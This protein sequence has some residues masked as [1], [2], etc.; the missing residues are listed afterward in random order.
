MIL[1]D[2]FNLIEKIKQKYYRQ[3][4]L[5]KGIGDDAAVFKQTNQSVVTAVDT[6]VEDVHF[7][8]NKT[9]ST[10]DIGYRCLAANISDL[11]AMGAL[12]KFYL[13]SVVIPSNWDE[14]DVLNVF[15]G[16]EE[17]A[18]EY[19]MD[20]IGGDT[21]SGKNFV[22]SIT[23][24]GYVDENK[25]RFRSDAKVDDIVFVTGTLG[26]AAIGLEVIFDRLEINNEA[27]FIKK[28]QRPEPNIVFSQAIKKLERVSLNDIS[29][30]ISS[31]L[32][33]IAKASNV[34]IMVED[35]LIPVNKEV[36]E[37]SEEYQAKFKYSGGEEFELVGTTSEENWL[38][39]KEIAKNEKIKVTKIGKVLELKRHHV[40]LD[41]Y[42]QVL[43]SSGYIHLK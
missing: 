2:E 32:N 42:D 26:N 23:V 33:E 30:G 43:K 16:L 8:K 13:V 18:Q 1:M 41:T 4:S 19:K 28:H 22:L 9:M 24:I 11:A 20:L 5:I 6:F 14:S 21:V 35:K 37:L 40:Y 29:D 10:K 7:I 36:K 27:Y 17:I 39:I 12:P 15:K 38:K 34:S 3:S 25:I 31:E